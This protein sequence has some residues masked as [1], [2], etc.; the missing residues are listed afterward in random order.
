MKLTK[1]LFVAIMTM[2]LLVV[3][4]GTSTFAWF[5]LSQTS[6]ISNFKI[7]VKTEEGMEVSLDGKAWT[8][9]LALA[10]NNVVFQDLTSADGIELT[11]INGGATAENVDYLLKY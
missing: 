5:T 3:T 11:T 6:E 4:F 2:A 8:N 10:D 9:K 1:K 7:Q